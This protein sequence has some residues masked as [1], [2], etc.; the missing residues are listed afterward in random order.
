M[1]SLESFL[2]K[3]L[4]A[5]LAARTAYKDVRREVSLPTPLLYAQ[6]CAVP[7]AA[8]PSVRTAGARLGLKTVPER[9][10]R[11]VEGVEMHPA[12]SVSG[13]GLS[14]PLAPGLSCRDL[15][16]KRAGRLYR[17]PYRRPYLRPYR[18]PHGLASEPQ[19]CA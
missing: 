12:I 6:P 17:R 15:A 9:A 2:N 5:A 18:R 11:R 4:A 16:D 19:A 7:Q 1:G 8:G 14:V 10:P 13:V 3:D